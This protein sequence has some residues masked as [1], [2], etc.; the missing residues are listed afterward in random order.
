MRGERQGISWTAALDFTPE[1][2]G[3]RVDVA[4]EFTVGGPRRL[5]LG[6]FL[7]WYR[8]Q[9]TRRLANLKRMMEAGEL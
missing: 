2:L 1:R 5:L 8:G 6:M 3:T 4:F 7:R 9:W